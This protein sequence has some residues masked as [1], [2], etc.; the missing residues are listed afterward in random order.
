MTYDGYVGRQIPLSDGFNIANTTETANAVQQSY[1]NSGLVPGN[2]QY[3][4]GTTPVI[5]DYITP[6]A[7]KE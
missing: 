3:G 4:K 2:K 7:G 5:P 6:T 1:I